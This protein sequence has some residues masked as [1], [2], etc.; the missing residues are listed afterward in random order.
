MIGQWHH[1]IGEET[2]K[3]T[4]G[5]RRYL[6][7]DRYHRR[8]HLRWRVAV[9]D[10]SMMRESG[11]GLLLGVVDHHHL[12]RIIDGMRTWKGDEMIAG[13]WV[14]IRIKIRLDR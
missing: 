14:V 9:D 12:I 8:H 1:W 4:T 6:H 2:E 11:A 3:G 7:L 13:P 5:G 10:G